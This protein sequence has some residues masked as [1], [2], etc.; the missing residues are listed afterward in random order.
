MQKILF[1][2]CSKNISGAEVSLMQM[3]NHLDLTRFLVY[4]VLP[5][6]SRLSLKV[7]QSVTVLPMAIKKISYRHILNP[8]EWF[9]TLRVSVSIR[10]EIRKK[11]IDIVYCNTF[12]SLP[13]CITSKIFTSVKI[14][15]HC[16]DYVGGS[17][18]KLLLFTLCDKIICVSKFIQGNLHLLKSKTTLCYVGIDTTYYQLQNIELISENSLFTIANVG[19][20]VEWKQQQHFIEIAYRISKEIKGVHFYLVVY[21]M[22]KN[23]EK[24][25][26]ALNKRIKELKLEDK[27]TV[28]SFQNDIRQILSKVDLLIHTAQNEP[29]GRIVAEALSMQVPVIAADTGGP[30]EVIR[31]NKCGFLIKE[32]NISQIIKKVNFFIQNPQAKAEFGKYGRETISKEFSFEGHIK[33]VEQILE[34]V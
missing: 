30:A 20:A 27:F 14:I 6:K 34:S 18:I 1:I 3:L 29:F 17:M 22:S 26:Q 11:G 2:C 5:L 10:K 23:G 33:N 31:D 28:Y 21:Q 4:V 9:R 7:P 13:Y 25:I 15:C 12:T 8:I 32:M 24:K 19:Q 16:R